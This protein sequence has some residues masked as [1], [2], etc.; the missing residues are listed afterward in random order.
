MLW[1]GISLTWDVTGQD[2]FPLCWLK[3]C[4]DNSILSI[5]ST[6]HPSFTQNN[7]KYETTIFS[8]LQGNGLI[9]EADVHTRCHVIYHL[10]F[11]QVQRPV[12]VPWA[13]V[14]VQDM[15]QVYAVQ[16]RCKHINDTGY[17][18]EW[19]SPV[20]STPQNSRGKEK[21]KKKTLNTNSLLR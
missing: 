19:S 18:S 5:N 17:W 10:S 8:F 4:L 14:S 9:D 13:E 11:V 1:P 7:K 20:Y 16:V 2:R 6:P 3:N 12:Q 21:E 15:C